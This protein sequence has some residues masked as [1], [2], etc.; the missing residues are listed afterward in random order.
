M[1][2]VAE[3]ADNP[4]SGIRIQKGLACLPFLPNVDLMTIEGSAAI[5]AFGHL[6]LV[7]QVNHPASLRA[8][9]SSMD[10]LS[11]FV[12][13]LFGVSSTGEVLPGRSSS[14]MNRRSGGWI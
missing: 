5:D 10:S 4:R 3:N 6:D 7:Q 2:A 11:G 9:P 12:V 1:Y 13:V 8:G 14:S